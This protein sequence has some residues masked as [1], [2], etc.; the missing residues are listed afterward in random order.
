MATEQVPNH[1]D[2]LEAA[3]EVAF[4]GEMLSALDPLL[5]MESLSKAVTFGSLMKAGVNLAQHVPQVMF[6]LQEAEL[7][8]RDF[9]FKDATF[10]ENAFYRRMAA[11][12]VLWEQEMMKVVENDDIDW[13][14]Q[15]R[16]RMVMAAMTS[17]FSPTN[18]LAG[19]PEA[20]KLAFST[21]GASVRQ[22]FSNF[23]SDMVSNRGYPSQVDKTAFEVGKNLAVTPG[24]VVHRTPMFELIHYTPTT[25]TVGRRPLLLLPPP[26]NKY[27]FWDLAPG[28]SMVEYAVGR[29]VDCFT[30]VWRDP[31]EDNG[32]WGAEAYL[33]SAYEAVDAVLEITG[34]DGVQVFGDCSGGM[35][36]AMLLAHQ[37]AQGTKRV[38]SGTLGVTVLD[39]GEPGGIGIT[40]SD[41][42][43]NKVKQRA[44]RKE[45]ISADDISSTFVWMRPNDLVWRY[46][47]DEWLLGRKPP[48]FDIMFWNADGQGMPAQFAYD[49]TAMSLENSL[50]KPGGMNLLGAELDLS[51][52]DIPTYHIAGLTDH[53]SPW[54]GCYAGARVMGGEKKFVLTPTGHVQSIIYPM[55]K[56]RAAFWTGPNLDLT[57]EAWQESAE[58][59]DDSWW[60]DWVD[61]ILEN[62]D[63]ERPAVPAAGSAKYPPIMPAPGR[64]VLGE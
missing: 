55:G 50:L 48:A 36:L 5:M 54:K 58:R 12:Y 30:I 32:D 14:T 44:E 49:M 10:A 61:W 47:I 28:R 33:T 1:D 29:G 26:V 60:S 15:E 63:G 11:S 52:V 3:A 22:G 40:A 43:L 42:G 51:A 31:R 45:V 2:E 59:T 37:A 6:G 38:T 4:G 27:Y 41:R 34:T 56:P 9:R 13:R 25:E 17:A 24:W 18:L 46:L 39:F 64:Y 57:P 53:I 20:L 19:N 7:P 21:G 35:I 16:A 23:V 62:A 8:A